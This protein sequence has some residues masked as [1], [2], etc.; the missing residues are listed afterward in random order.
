MYQNCIM[1]SLKANSKLDTS[2]GTSAYTSSDMKTEE[3]SSNLAHH[4]LISSESCSMRGVQMFIVKAEDHMT[5][6]EML[7]AVQPA[8][9][10]RVT[11]QGQF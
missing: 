9:P 7:Q 3:R 8:D 10:H 11:C 1:F 6:N 4:S 5:T 2:K